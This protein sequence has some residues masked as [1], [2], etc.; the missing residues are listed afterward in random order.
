M[1]KYKY[2]PLHLAHIEKAR[3]FAKVKHQGQV[4]DEGKDYFK[5]HIC[6]VVAILEEVTDDWRIICAGYLHDI[7]EDTE[8]TFLELAREFASN[9]PQLVY[10][11]THEGDKEHGF[12]FPRLHSKEAVLIKF[13]DRL[14]NLSR[15]KGWNEE[16]QSHY[17]RR[18]KFWK[19]S[20]EDEV[21]NGQKST[22]KETCE[23]KQISEKVRMCTKCGEWF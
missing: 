17:L 7:L 5:A 9:V 1:G 2:L 16:R 19:T 6:Q 11:V 10:E 21:V 3:E 12:Y 22:I 20:S 14:S 23:H 4:D 18:S 8:T 15:M 13:A